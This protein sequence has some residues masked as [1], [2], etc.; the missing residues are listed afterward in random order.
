M[1]SEPKSL[2]CILAF[3]LFSCGEY[4]DKS[5]DPKL[6]FEPAAIHVTDDLGKHIKLSAPAQRIVALSPG[7]VENLFSAGL[8][9]KIV[10]TVDYADYPEA[11]LAIPRVGSFADFSVESILSYEPDLV[12]GWV[13]GF[14]DF[15]RLR[16]RL[17]ALDIPT[18]ADEPK[19]L[20]DVASSIERFSTLGGTWNLPEAG[21]QQRVADFLNTKQLLRAK[22]QDRKMKPRVFYQI[23]HD[24]LQTL[25]QPHIVNF[26]IELCGGSNIFADSNMIAPQVNI[27]SVIDRNPD[28][29]LATIDSAQF[30]TVVDYWE[31]WPSIKAVERQQVFSVDSDLL[32]RH[33]LRMMDGAEQLCGLIDGARQ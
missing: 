12:I 19:T 27:E 7:I 13:S 4:A 5:V 32:S 1:F 30:E 18:F 29:I 17:A 16:D 2:V 26:L 9:D 14:A 3:A 8:G 15:E 28:I 11:A 21:V 33:T 10:A 25:G 31:Q 24:P 20:D 22:Y 6:A 23:W